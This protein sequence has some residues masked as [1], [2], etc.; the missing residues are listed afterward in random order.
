MDS[1]TSQAGGFFMFMKEQNPDY[2]INYP[3]YAGKELEREVEVSEEAL[4][5]I[6]SLAPSFWREQVNQATSLKHFL[7]EV[8]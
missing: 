6:A 3:E 2:I 7:G 8:C 5:L 4:N 1:Q